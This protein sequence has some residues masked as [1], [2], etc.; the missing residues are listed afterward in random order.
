MILH[1]KGKQVYR[2]LSSPVQIKEEMNFTMCFLQ[3][4]D[5]A[6]TIQGVADCDIKYIKAYILSKGIRNYQVTFY[7]VDIRKEKE[8]LMKAIDQVLK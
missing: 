4:K 1:F 5:V 3:N 7:P 8:S 6:N 2:P